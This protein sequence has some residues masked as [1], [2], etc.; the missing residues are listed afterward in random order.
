M[1]NANL[2]ELIKKYDRSIVL[3]VTALAMFFGFKYTLQQH[4]E[5]IRS[6]TPKIER[7]D[8]FLSAQE[9]INIRLISD[10]A[11]LKENVKE[12]RQDLRG[13]INSILREMARRSK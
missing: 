11:E 8:Q 3:I 5:I 9:Q 12:I 13:G 1:K 7:Y 10:V 2:L 6:R 4:D